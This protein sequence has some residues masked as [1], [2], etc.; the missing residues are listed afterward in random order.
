MFPIENLPF[1]VF[2]RNGAAH[3]GVAFED[4]IL[5][6]HA[7]SGLFDDPP[8][9]RELNAFM[10]RGRKASDRSRITRC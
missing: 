8:S 1:G 9:S 10:S 5:D 6:L 7:C 3:I 2:R 4:R